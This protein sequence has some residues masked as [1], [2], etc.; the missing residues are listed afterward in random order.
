MM[1]SDWAIGYT[2]HAG[3][4]SDILAFTTMHGGSVDWRNAHVVAVL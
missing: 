1:V 2:S 3:F 4:N